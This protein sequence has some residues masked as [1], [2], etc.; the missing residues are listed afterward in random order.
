MERKPAR[1]QR[2]LDR[3]FRH[4]LPAQDAEQRQQRAREHVAVHGAAARKDRLAGAAH[5]RRG[6]GIADRLQREIGFDAGAHIEVAV[7]EQRP[8]AVLALDAAQ[9]D[10]DLGFEGGIDRLAAEMPQ[11]HVFGWDGGIGLELEHP[12]AVIALQAEQSAIGGTKRRGHAGAGVGS[13][14]EGEA[15]A[16]ARRRAPASSAAR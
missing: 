12:V 7:V 15:H 10:G 5:V 2:D 11:Q 3:H 8:A 6:G 1:Q 4:A 9:I 14:G 13:V 16:A